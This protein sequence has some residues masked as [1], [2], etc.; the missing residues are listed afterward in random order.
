MDPQERERFARSLFDH[1]VGVLR[2]A[3]AIDHVAVV[4]DSETARAHAESLGAVALED[5]PDARSLAVVIDEA[6]RQLVERG[7]TSA[8][9]CMSDLPDLRNDDI[10]SVIRALSESE[11]VL[12]P[13]RLV[14][15][16]NVIAMTPADAL[17]SCLGHV[18]SLAR[19]LARAGDLNLTVSVQLSSGIAFDVDQPSDLARF[20]AR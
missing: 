8:L 2:N 4:S 9:I 15:G 10:A 18:D 16:T 11:V 1:V 5:A 20:R 6:L 3:P 13:D 7:A 17:P 14:E 19:H 12:V